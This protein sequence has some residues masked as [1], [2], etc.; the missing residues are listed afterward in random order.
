[1]QAINTFSEPADDFSS[2]V[3]L[4]RRPRRH[5]IV[6]DDLDSE[7]KPYG[8]S[9]S[10]RRRIRMTKQSSYLSDEDISESEEALDKVLDP[11]NLDQCPDQMNRVES[12]LPFGTTAV[13]FNKPALQLTDSQADFFVT[14]LHDCADCGCD[15][16]EKAAAMSA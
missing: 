8:D 9:S 14:H 7:M 6:S 10:C 12:D 2:S 4:K 5:E 3:A 11:I 13:A 1:M 15:C 16:N